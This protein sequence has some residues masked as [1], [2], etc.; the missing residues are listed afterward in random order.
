LPRHCPETQRELF[1]RY[2]NPNT[3]PSER[4]FIEDKLV[5]SNMGLVYNATGKFK[6]PPDQRDDVVQIGT[7]VLL[8]AVKGFDP[9]YGTTF[10]TYAYVALLRAFSN[11]STR[12]GCPTR[13]NRD[14]S[15]DLRAIG[16]TEAVLAQRDYTINPPDEDIALLT[17]I[18]QIRVA[19][20]RAERD[21]P[22][23]SLN[24]VVSDGDTELIELLSVAVEESS[25]SYAVA[26]VEADE[27]LSHIH[28]LPPLASEIVL[29]AFG[30]LDGKNQSFRKIAGETCYSETFV[31]HVCADAIA[32]IRQEFEEVEANDEVPENSDEAF[33][34]LGLSRRQ[35]YIWSESER[36]GH[37]MTTN[38]FAKHLGL[39][40]KTV[41]ESL[42]RI[43]S[44]I[45]S[46]KK[47][48]SESD[49]SSALDSSSH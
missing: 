39:D 49:V 9:E 10:S 13:T 32:L 21:A 43:Y 11:I 20:L 37:N 26:Y 18:P 27:L 8:G 23:I 16:R 12:N 42:R 46:N 35:W 30:F 47:T 1:H 31:Q 40:K 15:R 34:S 33:G 38:E 28:N 36:F 48:Q 22:H 24:A 2:S 17:G 5:L 29:R 3:D 4:R 44:V 7:L 41:I 19:Q 25:E 45:H 6:I 14:R